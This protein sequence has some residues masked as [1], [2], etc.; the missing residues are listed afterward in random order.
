[1]KYANRG[2]AYVFGLAL[3]YFLSSVIASAQQT[4]ILITNKLSAPSVRQSSVEEDE[5]LI[6]PSRP[7]I[8]NPAEFQKPGV[9]QIE[10]G[11]DGNFRADEFRSQQTAP[12]TVRFAPNERLL[13]DFNIDTVISEKNEM[14]RRETGVGDTRVGVQ[15]LAVKDTERHPA[16]AFA[17]YAKLPTA[18]SEKNLGTGRTDYRI[19]ALLSKN[20]GKTDIDFNAAYLNV[21]R[22]FGNRRV[23]GGQAAFSV[24]RGFKNNFGII[25]EIS[26]QSEDDVLPK[27]IFALGAVTYKVNKR[28]QFDTGLRFGLNPNAPRI[29]VFAGFTVGIGNP[30]KK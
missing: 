23:S 15:I 1:M 16:L 27:G 4:N 20:F 19:V 28:V 9:L 24:S 11:Y 14:G 25:G 8:A 2:F 7:G 6:N 12:L 22:E 5:D 3:I 13:F 17:F 18:S 21:G 26:G 30:F 10:Y 29:G